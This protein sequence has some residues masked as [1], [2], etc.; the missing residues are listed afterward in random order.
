MVF[1][2]LSFTWPIDQHPLPSSLLSWPF[3]P[4]ARA[5][6]AGFPVCFSCDDVKTQSLRRN[7]DLW[8]DTACQFPLRPQ[9]LQ[10][11]RKGKEIGGTPATSRKQNWKP[12]Y[13]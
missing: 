10:H 4:L 12:R 8:P 9:F 7:P 3:S 1:V 6:A 13:Q 2:E 5:S 11:L